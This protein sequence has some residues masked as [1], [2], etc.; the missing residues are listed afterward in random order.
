MAEACYVNTH[1]QFLHLLEGNA[2]MSVSCIKNNN[3]QQHP[4]I[5]L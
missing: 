1:E 5:K 4:K 3:T 2:T